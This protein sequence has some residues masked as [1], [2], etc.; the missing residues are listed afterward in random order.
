MP[1]LRL[2]STIKSNRTK[3]RPE[4]PKTRFRVETFSSYKRTKFRWKRFFSFI[5]FL[6]GSLVKICFLISFSSIYTK[7]SP[8]FSPIYGI[9]HFHGAIRQNQRFSSQRFY[10][11]FFWNDVNLYQLIE[12]KS[13]FLFRSSNYPLRIC[14]F[15]AEFLIRNPEKNIII[16]NINNILRNTGRKK[17][18]FLQKK[19][20]K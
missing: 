19:I 10:C 3:S 13:P 2:W 6:F 4:I 18:I 15:F 20:R 7:K 1:L 16:R 8:M 12:L 11:M 9:G 17:L 14:A 5:F